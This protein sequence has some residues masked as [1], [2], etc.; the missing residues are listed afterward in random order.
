MGDYRDMGAG[1][2]VING[3]EYLAGT[4][5]DMLGIG[6]PASR[7]SAGSKWLLWVA[8]RYLNDRDKIRASDD[9]HSAIFGLAG[10][11]VPVGAWSQW[12]V[13]T[14]LRLWDYESEF[15]FSGMRADMFASE[16]GDAMRQ[17]YRKNGWLVENCVIL[18]PGMVPGFPEDYL[19]EIAD[20]LLCLLL[21]AEEPAPEREDADGEGPEGDAGG[22]EG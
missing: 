8:Q 22:E 7:E 16:M 14:D 19:H 4:L 20:R 15:K 5:S 11:S 17:R 9:P 6:E 12:Q 13:F 10:N 1:P 18:T 21:D 3:K 2:I